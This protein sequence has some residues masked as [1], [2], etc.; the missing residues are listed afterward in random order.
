MCPPHIPPWTCLMKSF[1]ILDGTINCMATGW[2]LLYSCRLYSTP[3]FKTK[4][5]HWLNNSFVAADSATNS[6][7]G[8]G[9]T[10][11]NLQANN[12]PMSGSFNCLSARDSPAERRSLLDCTVEFELTK[13]TSDTLCFT[14]VSSLL[15]TRAWCPSSS[16]LSSYQHSRASYQYDV[17]SRS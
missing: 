3:F 16:G 5:C 11:L 14:S 12:G 8:G 1:F 17:V 7:M 6:E 2:P 13:S 9:L 10:C 15:I 4:E